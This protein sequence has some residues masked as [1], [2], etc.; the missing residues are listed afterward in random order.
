[1]S[2]RGVLT[3][4][5]SAQGSPNHSVVALITRTA[6]SLQVASPYLRSCCCFFA[7][8]SRVSCQ[9]AF[10]VLINPAFVSAAFLL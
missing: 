9:A 5:A 4:Y 10:H 3:C 8:S 2:R 7:L 1:V 6:S